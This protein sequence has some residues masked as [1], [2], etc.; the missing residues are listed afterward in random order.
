MGHCTF[1]C[2]CGWIL[3]FPLCTDFL[4]LLLWCTMNITCHY[5]RSITPFPVTLLI[6]Y[7]YTRSLRH[8]FTVFKDAILADPSPGLIFVK[9]WVIGRIITTKDVHTTIL[10]VC[11]YFASC[12]TQ[13]SVMWVV[14]D[15]EIDYPGRQTPSL[16]SLKVENLS[17]CR[18]PEN[19]LAQHLNLKMTG[20]VHKLR[21]VGS[22]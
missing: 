20:K 11:G 7:I 15:A 12:D 14:K 19:Y 9:T 17:W 8:K 3:F 1:I 13:D 2:T 21:H 6:K 5:T 4:W 16:G 10:K 18:Q 22:F